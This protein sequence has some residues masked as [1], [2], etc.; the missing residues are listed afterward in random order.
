MARL[1]NGYSGN[2][3]DRRSTFSDG[4]GKESEEIG[5]KG[6]EISGRIEEK[7]SLS[8]QWTWNAVEY[9]LSLKQRVR[10]RVEPDCQIMGVLFAILGK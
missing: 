8:I 7:R 10:T 6:D 3:Q 5:G 1:V 2:I 4:T 9:S